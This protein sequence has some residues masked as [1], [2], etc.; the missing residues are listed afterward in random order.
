VSVAQNFAFIVKMSSNEKK[1]K[2]QHKV[3]SIDEKMHIEAK[4]DTDVGTRVDLAALLGLSV[5]TL[6]TIMSK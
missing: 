6:N 5:L 3:F 1:M 4:V 2:K